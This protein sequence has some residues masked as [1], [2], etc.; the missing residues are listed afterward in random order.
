MRLV[1]VIRVLAAAACGWLLAGRAAAEP[2]VA[3]ETRREP[4]GEPARQ[5]PQPAPPQRHSARS[6]AGSPTADRAS[7]IARPERAPGG[8]GRAVARALLVAPRAAFWLLNA[9]V[10]AAAW[11]SERYQVP[12]RVREALFNDAGTAGVVPVARYETGFGATGG[13]RF[14]HRD[15]AGRGEHLVL[16]GAWGGPVAPGAGGWIDSGERLGRRVRARLDAR[17]EERPRDRF[18]GIGD[19]DAVAAVPAPV[20]PYADPAAVDTRFHQRLAAAAASGE[21]RLAGPLALQLTSGAGWRRIDAGSD[22]ADI[23]GSY[24]ADA[25]PGFGGERV[26][27]WHR[28]ALGVDTR[29]RP[30]RAE[31]PGPRATGVALWLYAGA[32]TGPAYGRYGGEARVQL[33]LGTRQRILVLRALAEAVAGPL[34]V[35]P[36]VDLPRLGGPELLRGY[37][38]DRFRDRA[39]A[40][41][42]IEYRFDL[43]GSLGGFLF[44]D[45]GRV[46][47][48][49]GDLASG[50]PRVGY[51]GGFDLRRGD[52]AIA[53]LAL[54]SSI[55]GGL[56][57]TAAFDPLGEAP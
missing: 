18:F 49:L 3:T 1:L 45:A 57:V 55:D 12:L 29:D 32:A 51:G 11:T 25:L 10:R 22:P 36:F 9:P 39:A 2:V 48:A 4:A 17:V 41:G 24:R 31:P 46:L 43:S 44:A 16:D 42:S 54:A 50:A 33:P 35:I 37:P 28:F 14:L 30:A 7:G 38:A 15:L 13:A 52:L 27:T 53:R 20:D 26:A 19:G 40:L 6:V 5:P 34:D 56:F 47:P 21:L 23:T 8:G